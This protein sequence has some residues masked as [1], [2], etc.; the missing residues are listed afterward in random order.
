MRPS[1][2]V[3]RHCTAGRPEEVELAAGGAV[4]VGGLLKQVACPNPLA[5]IPVP[6]FGFSLMSKIMLSGCAVSPANTA[7]TP[8]T[9]VPNLSRLNA[10]RVRQA[11]M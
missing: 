10:W 1:A 6:P 9:P 7:A 2:A 8:V 4:V 11:T 3:G 5:L